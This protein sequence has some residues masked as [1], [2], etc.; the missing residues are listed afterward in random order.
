MLSGRI[1]IVA[2]CALVV[3]AASWVAGLPH[4]LSWESLA[5]HQ[6][7]WR[8]WT[9]ARPFLSALLYVVAYAGAV[10]LSI[11]GGG[12]LTLTGGLLFG[13]VLG[14]AL[15]VLAATIGAVLLFLLARSTFGAVLA[16]RARPWLDRMR[17][18]LERDGF[19]GM[20]A[21]RLVPV[22]PFWLGNLAPA[23][24]GVRLAPFALS[25][26]IGIVP[27]T[28][29]LAWLG[30]GTGD[31]LAAGRRPDLSLL[32]SPGVLGPLLGLAALSLLPIVI[33]RRLRRGTA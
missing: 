4:L 33:R 17:P 29:V 32:T 2:A 28:A 27:A 19:W 24:L 26:L 22:V 20:L 14:A 1:L 7:T 13:A 12:V 31:V 9:D 8:G 25:T 16:A 11:P 5:A 3:L 18:T 15:A 10:A 30:A 23:L 6:A 21:L